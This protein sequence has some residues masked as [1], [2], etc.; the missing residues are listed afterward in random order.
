M[1][2]NFSDFEKSVVLNWVIQYCSGYKNAKNLKD[3][4]PFLVPKIEERKFR[5]IF[6]ELGAENGCYSSIKRGYWYLPLV[7]TDSEEITVALEA[8][9]ER[10]RR[11]LN[12]IESISKNE[13]RLQG[14]RQGQK[15][16]V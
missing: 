7:S 4:V 6:N 16:L 9:A 1:T 13:K 11:A 10:K 15:E 5:K 14:M 3:I 8:L 12:T 2:K